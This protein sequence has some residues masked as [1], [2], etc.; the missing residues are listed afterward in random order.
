MYRYGMKHRPFSIG[1]QP[2][3]GLV[4]VL[5]SEKYF[6]ELLY[7]RELSQDEIYKYE[8]EAIHE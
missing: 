7:D 5:E 1:T 4:E 6:N 3:S 8:L 2:K